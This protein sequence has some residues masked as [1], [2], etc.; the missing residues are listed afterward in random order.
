MAS[1]IDPSSL[2]P[3]PL[4]TNVLTGKFGSLAQNRK[5]WIIGAIILVAIIWYFWRRRS[6]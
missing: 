4:P 3:G 1:E 6:A 5:V 2:Q